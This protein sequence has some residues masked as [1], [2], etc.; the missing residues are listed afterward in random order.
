VIATAATALAIDQLQLRRPGAPWLI[1]V[2]FDDCDVPDV[3][4][5]GGRSLASIQR[6]DLF[7]DHSDQ[8]ITKL[9]TAVLRILRGHSS[10]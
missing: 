9:V 8:G 4:I 5:G 1:P 2:R 10:A 6:A 7:G 3:D